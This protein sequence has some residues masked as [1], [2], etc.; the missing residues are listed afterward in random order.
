MSCHAM[1]CHANAHAMHPQP[2]TRMWLG[3]CCRR[4]PKRSSTLGRGQR[5]WYRT[6]PTS[7]SCSQ[8]HQMWKVRRNAGRGATAMR[9]VVHARTHTTHF[10]A[11][12]I[13]FKA[14]SAQTFHVAWPCVCRFL[15]LCTRPQGRRLLMPTRRSQSGSVCLCADDTDLPH[16][17]AQW[18]RAHRRW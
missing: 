4:R 16:I 14:A 2:S 7:P 8:S 6:C 12:H 11:H 10:H 1:S 3:S 5:S 15:W 13:A 9:H 18:S 17:H